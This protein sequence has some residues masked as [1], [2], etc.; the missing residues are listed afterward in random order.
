MAL[1]AMD[2]LL[3]SNE[4]VFQLLALL[5]A[6]LIAGGAVALLLR[7]FRRRHQNLFF[8]SAGDLRRSL[9]DVVRAAHQASKSPSTGEA[10]LVG[11]GRL[12]YT[13]YTMAQAV[14]TS[15]SLSGSAKEQ[16]VRDL[17]ELLVAGSDEKVAPDVAG[18]RRYRVSEIIKLA[19]ETKS[20]SF[21]WG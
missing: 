20:G 6:I 16:L 15:T 17:E 5:P 12:L 1:S 3:K 8:R 14:Q 10:R 13:C 2:K 19:L 7:L 4:L 18:Q 11:E 21:L 9:L